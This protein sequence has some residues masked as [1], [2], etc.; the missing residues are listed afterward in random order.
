VPGEAR[1]RELLK[2]AKQPKKLTPKQERFVQEYLVDLNAT[3]A[4]VRA[5]YAERTA[6][7]QASRLLRNVK[8]AQAISEAKAARAERTGA[9]A[10]AAIAELLPSAHS[11]ILDFLTWNQYGITWKD[12]SEIPRELAGAIAEVSETVTELEEGGVRRTRRLKLNN[13]LKALEMLM[14]HLGMF[15]KDARKIDVT[16]KTPADRIRAYEEAKANGTL[17]VI[18]GGKAS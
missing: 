14:R 3:A 1:R 16:I 4:A 7:S 2:A 5:G 10:D 13:K 12:S 9:D 8:V 17:E 6:E 15:E 11:N 18:K